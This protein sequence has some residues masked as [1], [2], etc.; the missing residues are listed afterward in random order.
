MSHSGGIFLA[1]TEETSAP[2]GHLK[3]LSALFLCFRLFFERITMLIVPESQWKWSTHRDLAHTGW[4]KRCA[5][6]YFWLWFLYDLMI[7]C[8]NSQQRLTGL[9]NW[10]KNVVFSN[11][12]KGLLFKTCI[13]SSLVKIWLYAKGN[14]ILLADGIW[15][16]HVYS[17]SPRLTDGLFLK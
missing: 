9:D 2:R 10:V 16:W 7:C 5:M 14:S 1:W 13:Y 4:L 12:K 6:W 3:D 15:R 11:L 17:S 8:K